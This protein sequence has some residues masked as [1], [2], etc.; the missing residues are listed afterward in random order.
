MATAR[1]PFGIVRFRVAAVPFHALW[2]AALLFAVVLAH[3]ACAASSQAHLGA[4]GPAVVSSHAASHGGAYDQETPSTASPIDAL[5]ED[6]G[7][8]PV[9]HQ[10]ETCVSSQ[11][12]QGAELP[13]PC[14]APTTEAAF[15]AAMQGRF[16]AVGDT[17]AL[18]LLR[19]ATS[20]VVQQV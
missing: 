8:Y 3:G 4:G 1:S 11:P 13:V 9:H 14:A 18:P 10:A 17:S 16:G 5:D 2:L 7:G 15:P 20:S 19:S 12:Q 6:G